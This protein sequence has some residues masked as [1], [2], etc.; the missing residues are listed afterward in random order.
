MSETPTNPDRPFVSRAGEK[1]AHA[2]RAFDLPVAGLTAA[3]FGCNVGGFTDCLLRA[4][5]TRVHALDTGYGVLDWRLRNDPRV[6]VMERTNALHA[7]PPD[8]VPPAALVVIDL[9]WTRQ[10]L[11]VPAAL[12]WLKSGPDSRIITLVK[13][14]YE[15]QGVGVDLPPRAVLSEPDARRVLGLVEAELPPLG[16]R[17]LD[18]TTSPI[19]GG[20]KTRGNTEFLLLLARAAPA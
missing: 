16:V 4:G 15:A 9:A 6:A 11:A 17:V 5:A 2:L 18:R 14:H 12:R 10:K 7:A 13:P 20:S 8:G 3:D 19:V 1:L